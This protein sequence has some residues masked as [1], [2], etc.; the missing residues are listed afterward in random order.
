M[1]NEPEHRMVSA[2]WGTL[3][4]YVTG[5]FASTKSLI[6]LNGLY[7]SKSAWIK[8]MRYPA[9][10]CNYRMIFIDYRGSG[11]S[12]MERHKRFSFDE[13]VSDIR[14]IVETERCIAPNIV[15]YSIGGVAA[16]AYYERYPLEVGSLV[17]LSTGISLSKQIDIMIANLIDQLDAGYRFIDLIS[18]MYPLNHS[19]DYLA[20]M[21]ENN[22]QIKENYAAYNAD[23]AAFGLLLKS[24]RL[25]QSK[26]ISRSIAVPAIYIAGEDDLIFPPKMQGELLRCIAPENCHLIA[27]C[28]HA[29]FIE[30]YREVNTFI[31]EFLSKM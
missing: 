21:G 22:S 11:N 17:L 13:I 30:K 15:G 1:R 20:M 9:F 18:F 12:T 7:H 8:Q 14:N 23:T 27:G 2:K 28:G 6:F 29:S 3:A 31:T 4:Y 25:R 5:N 16:L 19:N 10:N 26:T 24:F